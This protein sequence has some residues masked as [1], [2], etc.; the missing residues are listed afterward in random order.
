MKG[1]GGED[2]DV[3]VIVAKTRDLLANILVRLP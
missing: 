1:G 3:V 2:R